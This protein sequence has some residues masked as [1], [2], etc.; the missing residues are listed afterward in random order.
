LGDGRHAIL[1]LI[2]RIRGKH[3]DRGSKISEVIEKI[4]KIFRQIL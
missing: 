2:P 3:R 1:L 4:Q